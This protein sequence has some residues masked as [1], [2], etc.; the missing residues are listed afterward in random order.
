MVYFII[1]DENS[2][3]QLKENPVYYGASWLGLVKNV[4]YFIH[5]KPK[6]MY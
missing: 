6:P 3:N 2:M 1:E 4:K 5:P